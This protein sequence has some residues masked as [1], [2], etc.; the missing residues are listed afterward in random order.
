MSV[1]KCQKCGEI[2]PTSEFYKNVATVD[3]YQSYCKECQS[4]AR[5]QASKPLVTVKPEALA[6]V[7]KRLPEDPDNPL[8]VF[9]PRELM[10]ELHR[11]GYDGELTITSRVNIARM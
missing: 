5:R 8:S 1:K 10:Q 4:A 3:G 9:T 11:R 6:R 7:N 2:K